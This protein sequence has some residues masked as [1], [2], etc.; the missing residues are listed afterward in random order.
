LERGDVSDELLKELGW[1]EGQMQAFAERMRQQLEQNREE[2]TSEEQVRQRQCQEM[3]KNLN[4]KP[5]EKSVRKN[6]SQPGGATRS[7][8]GRNIPVPIEY[9]DAYESFTRELGRKKK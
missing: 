2:L 9:R 5:Q 1:T 7:F 6:N 4:F 8:G 3:L